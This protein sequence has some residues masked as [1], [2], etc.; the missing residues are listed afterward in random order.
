MKKTLDILNKI[1]NQAQKGKIEI[2]NQDGTSWNFFVGLKNNKSDEIN[3]GDLAVVVQDKVRLAK[4]L[5]RYLD[6]ARDFYC[7]D[8]DYY[9]LTDDSLDEKLIMDLL[10]NSSNYNLNNFE[11]FVLERTEMLKEN[12]ISQDEIY[13]G[14]YLDCD[15]IANIDKNH[16][17]LEAPYKFSFKLQNGE[18]SFM[19]PS[20]TFGKI[21][22]KVVV[23]AIQG[24]KK[25][26]DNPL[27]KKLDRHFRKLN[28]DVDMN[29]DI[30]SQ[31]STNALVSMVGFVS[32]IKSIGAKEIEAV[33]FLPVRYYT[34]LTRGEMLSQKN[35]G[36]YED[37]LKLHD[38]NQFNMTNRFTNTL[39]RYAHHFNLGT[40]FDDI[41]ET[42]HIHLDEK[43]S[44][45]SGNIIYDIDKEI[46]EN[47]LKAD[48]AL[49]T[50]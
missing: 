31:V 1:L 28:K 32:Y 14:A 49:G 24:L 20:V 9:D 11:K 38:S 21:K 30:L 47:L 16:S 4:H 6:V 10:I 27:S 39:L 26:Q 42:I 12:G 18:E 41:T 7:L 22:D 46:T 45:K 33:N 36:S 44:G 48:C 50:Q 8:K 23:Y 13:L 40:Y 37:F 2:Q 43:V 3:N 34:Q 35:K 19:L 25:K 29:D 17:N 5:E 15:M